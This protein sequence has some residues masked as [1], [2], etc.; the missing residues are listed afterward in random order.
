MSRN[1]PACVIYVRV[2]PCLN[3]RLDHA[4]L[5][6]RCETGRRISRKELLVEILDRHLPKTSAFNN[7]PAP[8]GTPRLA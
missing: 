6:R 7:E 4:V 1:A 8:S 2:T 3:L 5:R